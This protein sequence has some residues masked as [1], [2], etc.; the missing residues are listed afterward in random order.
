MDLSIIIISFN[1]KT[2]LRE[3]LQAVYRTVRN[4]SFE[5]IV[6][7]NASGDGSIDMV[8]NEFADVQVIVNEKNLGFA[9]A[10]N[11]A[12]TISKG[13]FVLLLNSDAFLQE[14][15]VEILIGHLRN[16]PGAFAAGPKIVFPDGRLQSKGEQFPYI[17]KSLLDLT[18]VSRLLYLRVL[19]VLFPKYFWPEDSTR[20]VDWLIGCCLMARHEAFARVGLLSEKFFFYGEEA[21]WCYRAKKKCGY[22]IWY[23]SYASVIHCGGSSFLEERSKWDQRGVAMFYKETGSTFLGLVITMNAIILTV[24]RIGYLK[25]R[26]TKNVSSREHVMHYQ[27][28][29]YW[30]HEILKLLLKKT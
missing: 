23:I 12:L 7:D 27:K 16:H 22:E 5:V 29:L 20:P 28:E 9:K 25:F 15:T 4:I 21:E 30:H 3:C 19:Y 8:R 10:N 26:G 17:G 6:V 24:L 1:T 11:Q 13:E 2:L 18:R 14:N